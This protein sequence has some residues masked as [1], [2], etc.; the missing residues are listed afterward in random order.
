MENVKDSSVE[1]LTFLLCL[2]N[3]FEAVPHVVQPAL[4]FNSVHFSDLI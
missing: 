2:A 3:S 4:K 1:M